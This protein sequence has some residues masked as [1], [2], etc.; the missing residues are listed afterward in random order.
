MKRLNRWI[1]Y[2]AWICAVLCGC[3]AL[4]AQDQEPGDAALPEVFHT[5]APLH[6]MCE[7][8]IVLLGESPTHAFGEALQYKAELVQ[9]LVKEC[10]FQAV[11][12][13]SGF[14]D[15][16]HLER[17]LRAGQ[18]VPRAAI[19]AA[20]GGLWANQEVQALVPFLQ[21]KVQAGTLV[22]GGL[23][24]QV[25]AG[26]YASRAMADDLIL[27]LHGAEKARCLG[28]LHRYFSWQYTQD[29][30]YSPAAKDEVVACLNTI[31]AALPF[32]KASSSFL[33]ESNAMI[34]SLQRNLSRNFTEDDFT[35]PDQERRWMQDRDHS[36]YLNYMWLQH[37]L[38]AHAKIIVWAATVHTAKSLHGVQGVT[39]R[40][41]LGS[42][43][44]Q[45]KKGK[46]FSLG[47]SAFAGTYAFTHQPV[48][49]LTRAPSAS[50]EA[51]AVRLCD[52]AC[53]LSSKQLHQR[54]RALGRLLG[55]DFQVASWDTVVDGLVVFRQEHAPAWISISSR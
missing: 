6:A 8:Q 47:F 41:T 16:V 12:F 52:D 26:T 29:S 46:V 31:Q 34:N 50:V 33:E 43:L 40:V 9:R 53:Y 11:F 30:P 42:Y 44:Y 55:T 13:E 4:H 14:Y 15:Y 38:P 3:R 5:D 2:F 24:D 36:M 25:G 19:S 39:D 27:P 7:K 54:H 1:W 23:D 37:R 10:H 32:V 28:V 48:R 20:I 22:L 51:W 45:E 21:Q 49:D 17:M 18:D 35:Q